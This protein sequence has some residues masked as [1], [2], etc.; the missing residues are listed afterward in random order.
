MS[1]DPTDR[2]RVAPALG[3]AAGTSPAAAGAEY[4]PSSVD[5][6][7]AVAE[8]GDLVGRITRRTTK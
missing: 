5:H 3:P 8:E 1:R 2:R 6:V 7:L 4:P